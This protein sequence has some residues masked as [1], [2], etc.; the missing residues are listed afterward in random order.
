MPSIADIVDTEAQ[1]AIHLFVVTGE[2]VSR[3]DWR[4]RQAGKSCNVTTEPERQAREQKAGECPYKPSVRDI[5]FHSPNKRSKRTEGG[6]GRT[7]YLFS[8]K[9]NPSLAQS[10]APVA[11]LSMDVSTHA[12]TSLP[13]RS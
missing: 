8:I 12:Q 10:D 13:V 4:Q 7:R 2:S 9:S 6:C 11:G 5:D 3:P 1:L